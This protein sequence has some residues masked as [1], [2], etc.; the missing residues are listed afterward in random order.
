MTGKPPPVAQPE[1]FAFTPE[2]LKRAE[3]II[4]KYPSGFQQSAVLP[5]LD[6]AQRQAGNWLPQAAMDYVAGL[7]RMA[8]I[9]VYEVATFYTMFNLAPVGKHF[10]QLCRTTPCWL[11]GSDAIE[12][13]CRDKL[14][15]GPGESTADGKFTIGIGAGNDQ[16]APRGN[17]CRGPRQGESERLPLLRKAHERRRAR[18]RP[19]PRAPHAPRFRKA[20]PPPRLAAPLP[21]RHR[22]RLETSPDQQR[23]LSGVD[24]VEAA[25]K[26]LDGDVRPAHAALSV[27]SHSSRTGQAPHRGFR[28]WHT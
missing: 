2:N 3:A 12:K 6:L 8:P 28:A 18:L 20:R 25:G 10:I 9:R 24:A 7:L 1:S 19:G 17:A 11:R 22:Q 21:H 14:G 23:V 15:I 16:H 5:L 4:A 13:A 26:H 27:D